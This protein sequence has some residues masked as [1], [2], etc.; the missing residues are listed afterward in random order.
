[1]DE[2]DPHAIAAMNVAAM[3]NAL[4]R[5]KEV[6]LAQSIILGGTAPR[7]TPSP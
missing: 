1:L 6:E 3:A 5:R 2:Q 4:P 7:R